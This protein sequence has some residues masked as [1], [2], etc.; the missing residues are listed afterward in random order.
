M[1]NSVDQ[2][3]SGIIKEVK[4]PVS[5]TVTMSDIRVVWKHVDQIRSP[6][7]SMYISDDFLPASVA[8]LTPSSPNSSPNSLAA[9]M[10][11]L[12]RSTRIRHLPDHFCHENFT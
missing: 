12:H 2:L 10:P 9:I 11:H 1:K 7:V 3:G 6:I 8:D 4:S 5:Y